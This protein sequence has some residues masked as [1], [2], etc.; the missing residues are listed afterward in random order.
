M[1]E[2]Q[3]HT[4][5]VFLERLFW[6]ALFILPQDDSPVC[7]LPNSKKR[8]SIDLDQAGGIPWLESRKVK[9][10][11]KEFELQLTNNFAEILT[12]AGEIHDDEKG[13]TWIV[14]SFTDALQ[15]LAKQN[16]RKGRYSKSI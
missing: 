2:P 12:V 4:N 11:M 13:S 3:I 16:D 1:V 10:Y 5:L 14:P 8:F 7:S 6:N 15:K 9:R